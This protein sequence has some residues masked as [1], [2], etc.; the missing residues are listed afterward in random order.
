MPIQEYV[1][2]PLF[3]KING[4]YFDDTSTVMKVKATVCNDDYESSK[5]ERRWGHDENE[6]IKKRKTAKSP[7]FRYILTDFIDQNETNYFTDTN[8]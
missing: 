7:F 5:D 3:N 2:L 8:F 4:E 1:L 6:S